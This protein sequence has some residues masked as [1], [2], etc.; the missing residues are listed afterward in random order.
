MSLE[1]TPKTVVK[2]GV[3]AEPRNIP[4]VQ[5]WKRKGNYAVVDYIIPDK[6]S[7]FTETLYHVIPEDTYV[8]AHDRHYADM[9]ESS[10]WL[11]RCDEKGVIEYEWSDAYRCHVPVGGRLADGVFIGP[12]ELVARWL[13]GKTCRC[14]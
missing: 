11:Y 2:V 9:C 8:V 4:P 6:S 3:I 5:V 12:D 10:I 14:D 1:A 7:E 13:E